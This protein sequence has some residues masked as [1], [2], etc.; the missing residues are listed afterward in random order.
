MDIH[1]NALLE[2]RPVYHAAPLQYLPSILAS[3]ELRSKRRV[4]YSMARPT[5]RKRDIALGLGDYIHCSFER[6]SP[7]VLD[8][9]KKGYPHVV[10]QFDSARLTDVDCALLPC[11]TKAWR[12]KW[13]CVP[14]SDPLD[15]ARLMRLYSQCGRFHGMEILVK[16]ALP[17]DSLVRIETSSM[18]EYRLVEKIS[19]RLPLRNDVSIELVEPPPILKYAA[20][21]LSVIAEYFELCCRVEIDLAIPILPFD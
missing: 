4:G 3:G 11:S 13:Q 18:E 19:Q 8:K 21:N 7:I 5:A 12:S 20:K 2:L 14:V 6:Q 15:M 10:L 1:N 9:L 16:G 17:L